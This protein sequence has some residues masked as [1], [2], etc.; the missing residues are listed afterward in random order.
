MVFPNLSGLQ[1]RWLSL[2]HPSGA[3][4][5]LPPSQYDHNNSTPKARACNGKGQAMN[6]QAPLRFEQKRP[7][8]GEPRGPRHRIKLAESSSESPHYGG[9]GLRGRAEWFWQA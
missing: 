2:L 8:A 5:I 1:S 3:F 4:P 9:S 7:P 6:I